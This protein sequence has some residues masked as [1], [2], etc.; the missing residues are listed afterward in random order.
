MVE[1]C[2]EWRGDLAA[3][4]A[5][6][7]DDVDRTRVVAHIDR[8]DACRA[9][10]REL[11]R[12]V[13]LLSSADPAWL[14]REALPSVELPARIIAEV[15]AERT[16]RRHRRGM[17]VVGIAASALLVALIAVTLVLARGSSD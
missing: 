15:R 4:A 8:R 6:G 5:G 13:A 10:Y 11:R 1:A 16:R 3:L 14:D 9:E 12:A 7:L 17:R 2:R